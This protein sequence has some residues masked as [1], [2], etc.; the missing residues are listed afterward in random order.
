MAV[1]P[2]GTLYAVWQDGRFTGARDGIAISRSSDGGLTWS[3][4]AR[5]NPDPAVVAFTPQVHVRADGT[6]GVTYFDLRSDT[7]DAPLATDYWLARSVDGASWTETHL[8]GPFDMSTA[9]LAGGAYFLG[10]Y[11]G[12]ASSGTTFLPFYTRTTGSLE[13]RTDVFIA[14]IA[15]GTAGLAYAAD[16]AKRS[17]PPDPD[18]VSENLRTSVSRRARSGIP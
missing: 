4:P 9:P 2:S 11:M 8:S 5:V 15:A 18:R 12:L 7:P 17:A 13:N 3:Q 10:D 1:A 6:I 14:R 16:D